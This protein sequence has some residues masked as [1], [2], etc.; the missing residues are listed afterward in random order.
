MLKKG[1]KTGMRAHLPFII[2][3]I[4]L[5]VYLGTKAFSER[6]WSGWTEFSAQTLLSTEHWAKEGFI[7]NKFLFIPTGY[8]KVTQYLD[9]PEMRHHARGIVSGGLIG[10][11]LYYTHYPGGYLIP[12]AL[13]MKSGVEARPWFRLISLSFSL[14][15]LVFMYLFVSS[16]ST[17]A[18]AFVS[19]LYYG[20]SVMFLDFADSLANQPLDDLLKFVILFLSVLA[21]KRYGKK[22]LNRFHILAWALYFILSISSYDSTFFIFL[23]LIGLDLAIYFS[24]KREFSLRRW[25]FFASA[26]V[27]AFGLQMLQ[28]FWYLGWKDMLLD[29]AGTFVIRANSVP[30]NSF[31]EKH[32]DSLLEP[33]YSLMNIPVELTL[34]VILIL[35]AGFI[36]FKKITAYDWPNPAFIGVLLVAGSVFTLVF[37]FTGH[38][39]YEG[40][41]W[42][43]AVSILTGAS[44]VLLFM[45]IRGK[46]FKGLGGRAALIAAFFIPALAFTWY[47]QASRTVAY[48]RLWPN[49]VFEEQA[50]SYLKK[51]GS[52]SKSDDAVIFNIQ[53]D[54]KKLNPQPNPSEEY[55]SGRLILNFK[56]TA[57]FIKDYGWIRRRSEYPFDSIIVTPEKNIMIEA[58]RS[59][60][61]SGELRKIDDK[62]VL[63][64]ER[65][66]DRA[67][68]R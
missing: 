12:H 53:P 50:V 59:L 15:G 56:N 44:T 9:E 3:C 42:A 1:I 32:L 6:G 27:L 39:D 20:A 55:Y 11:R 21:M 25:A 22:P 60:S 37:S 18:V 67:S 48:L 2:F 30:G 65:S 33:S 49:N 24:G 10:K 16:I 45:M 57:D 51:L 36:F 63:M 58:A 5:S 38:F 61:L 29:I 14:A 41:Q 7:K 35:L 4:L 23:W 28:N 54:F 62:Y 68:S 34:G 40:R 31:I 26:P 13:L 47:M 46:I 64:V 66:I 19:S 8:S 43:P 52:V 17:P